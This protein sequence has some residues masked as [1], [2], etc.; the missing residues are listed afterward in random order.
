[1]NSFPN[2]KNP[3]HFIAT[4]G[5]IGKIPFAPGTW[6]SLFSFLLFILLSHYIN[7]HFVVFLIILFSVWICE[8]ASADLIE[9][10]HSSIVIDELAGMWVALLQALYMTT[11]SSRTTYAVLA[12][13]FF[14][15]FD[16][17]KPFPISY[18]DKNYKN[19]LGIVLDDLIAGFLAI[20]PAMF[21]IYLGFL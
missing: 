14:R 9:K 1:M 20:I 19:G 8:K 6:G 15:I 5:G 21:L 10:D 4:L 12:F 13:I 17:L 16:I 18:F 3:I 2:L 11:Q 7:M